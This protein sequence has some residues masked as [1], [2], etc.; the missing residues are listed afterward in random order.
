MEAQA[1]DGNTALESSPEAN[2]GSDH[3]IES[4]GEEEKVPWNKDQRWIQWRK[5]EKT[6][7]ESAER[8]TQYEKELNEYK[9]YLQ[10][11]QQGLSFWGQLQQDPAKLKQVVDLLMNTQPVQDPYAQYDPTVAEKLR[12]VDSLNEKVLTIEQQRVRAELSYREQYL[13][14][15][16]YRMCSEAKITTKPLQEAL[17]HYAFAALQRLTMGQD[18]RY[19][20]QQQLEAAFKEGVRVLNEVRKAER[21]SL[22]VSN[23]PASGTKTGAPA[24]MESYG[25]DTDRRRA[26][27]NAFAAG[28]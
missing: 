10:Q 22:S 1:Q 12:A 7:R 11:N 14:N 4:Q 25:S 2:T 19:A 17:S 15:E 21:E 16:F 20:N 3:P 5:E 28:G 24:R 26:L 9:Q 13:D 8:A 6:L 27:A 23:L 18:P